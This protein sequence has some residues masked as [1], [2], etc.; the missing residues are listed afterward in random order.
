MSRQ[1]NQDYWASQEDARKGMINQKQVKQNEK[2]P[3]KSSTVT[4]NKSK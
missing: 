4:S 3:V 1:S 2:N